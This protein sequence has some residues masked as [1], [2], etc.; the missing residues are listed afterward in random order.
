MEAV[1]TTGAISRAKKAVQSSSQIITTNKPTPSFFTGRMP[2]LS[3]NQQRQ[4][5]EEKISHSTDLLTPSSP[6]VCQLCLWLLIAD[7]CLGGRVATPLISPP[8]PK[9]FINILNSNWPISLAYQ[10]DQVSLLHWLLSS[11]IA[12]GLSDYI[13]VST[14]CD[15]LSLFF[16]SLQ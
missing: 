2:F 15:K 7:G 5:T 16:Q 4:S 13:T 6:G 8:M 14:V 10:K 3:P 11:A 9:A 12:Q 1:A